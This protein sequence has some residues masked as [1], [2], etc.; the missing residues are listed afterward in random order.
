MSQPTGRWLITYAP[1]ELDRAMARLHDEHGVPPA[2]MASLSDV[3]TAADVATVPVFVLPEAGTITVDAEALN[4]DPLTGVAPGQAILGARAEQY[5]T[6]PDVSFVEEAPPTAL[7]WIDESEQTWV[8]SALGIRTTDH[9]GAGVVVGIV[10]SGISAHPDLQGRVRPGASFVE[11]DPLTTDGIGHGTHCAGL[12]AGALVAADGPR[13]GI[14]PAAEV[15]SLRVFGATEKAPETLVRAGIVEGARSCHVM[16]LAAGRLT[17]GGAFF[18]EDEQLARFL[19][20]RNVLLFA[21]AGNDSDRSI[22][23]VKPT[24]APANA[25]FVPAIGAMTAGKAVWNTSN[26]IGDDPA[27]RVDAVAPGVNIRSAWL[28]GRS[29]TLSGTSAAT[30]V[31]AGAAAALWSRD[32]T[33]PAAEVLR[34]LWRGSLVLANA[35]PGSAG[36][37][38]LRVNT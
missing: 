31:A 17:A 33:L 13:Y 19:V 1:G 27:T 10:D 25:P 3:G 21:A 30:A 4:I 7:A 8:L 12:V 16:T 18:P 37:G 2:A 35:P 36:A 11:G 22:G 14:A 15:T 6:R 9:D 29:Q 20:T 26:G 24:R 5:F 28:G 38:Q 34:N 23:I 32:R